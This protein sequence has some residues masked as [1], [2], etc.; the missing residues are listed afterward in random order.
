[1]TTGKWNRA[2]G[3]VR[4]LF[5]RFT[6]LRQLFGRSITNRHPVDRGAFEI[7]IGNRQLGPGGGTATPNSVCVGT[8]TDT[9]VAVG[10]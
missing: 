3:P 4:P 8:A 9:P 7:V 6:F 10:L 2:P 1:M 5:S